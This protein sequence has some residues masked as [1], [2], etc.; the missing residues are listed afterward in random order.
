MASPVCPALCHI[1]PEDQRRQGL[2]QSHTAAEGQSGLVHPL[3][4]SQFRPCPS[5]GGS[6]TQAPRRR[7]D[8]TFSTVLW[9]GSLRTLRGFRGFVRV[10]SPGPRGLQAAHFTI[11]FPSCPLLPA[12]SSRQEWVCRRLWLGDWEPGFG[13]ERPVCER[14]CAAHLLAGP[15]QLRPPV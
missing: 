4:H 1:N 2:A 12:S 3:V 6:W 8:P 10:L 7:E 14:G 9:G 5:G 13:A 11:P 15:G